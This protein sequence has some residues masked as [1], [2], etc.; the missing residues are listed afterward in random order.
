MYVKPP[1]SSRRKAERKAHREYFTS[2]GCHGRAEEVVCTADEDL[3]Q[4]VKDI[5]GKFRAPHALLLCTC[6]TEREAAME[7]G[8]A[9]APAYPKIPQYLGRSLV[10]CT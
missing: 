8:A 10:V 9:A 1:P 4:R 7:S 3:V 2:G 5:T 6:A